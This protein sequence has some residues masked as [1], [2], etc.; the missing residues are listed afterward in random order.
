[1][2]LVFDHIGRVDVS[3]GKNAPSFATIPRP[4]TERPVPYPRIR[5]FIRRHA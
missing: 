1:V 5:D 3:E 2:P 4:L